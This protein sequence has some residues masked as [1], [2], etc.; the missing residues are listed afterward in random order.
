MLTVTQFSPSVV[1]LRSEK[2]VRTF[3]CL[4]LGLIRFFNKMVAEKKLPVYVIVIIVFTILISI[5]WLIFKIYF[6]CCKEEETGL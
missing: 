1:N 5:I 6:E 4:I 3:L 2:K